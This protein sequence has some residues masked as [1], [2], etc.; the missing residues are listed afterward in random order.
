MLKKTVL[1][2]YIDRWKISSPKMNFGKDWGYWK[3]S[4]TANSGTQVITAKY[5][6]FFQ[7][8]PIIW[9][10]KENSNFSSFGKCSFPRFY[11][12]V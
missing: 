7:H 12:L 1:F 5:F 2:R 3:K 10:F 6:D 8:I 9:F 4:I 11:K